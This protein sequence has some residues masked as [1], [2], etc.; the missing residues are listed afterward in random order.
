MH[1]GAPPPRAVP[2]ARVGSLEVRLATKAHEVDEAQALRYRIF[3]E[4]MSAT[5]SP[6]MRERQRDFDHYDPLWEHLLVIDHNT[7]GTVIGTYRL[8]RCGP[9]TPSSELYTNTE[10]DLAPLLEQTGVLVELGRMCIHPDYRTGATAQLLWRGMAHYVFHH[11]VQLM[12]GCA[13]LREPT[14]TSSPFL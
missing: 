1:A 9:Q 2:V 3:Y 14:P 13:A 5:P 8:H 7:G 11:D 12:F 4:E 6:E 10:Y